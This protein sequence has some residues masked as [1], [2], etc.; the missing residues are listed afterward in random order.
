MISGYY[1][2]VDR[3]AITNNIQLSQVNSTDINKLSN[4]QIKVTLMIDQ[5]LQYMTRAIPEP[6]A[7][8]SETFGQKN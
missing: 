8:A 4:G 2:C 7:V 6:L 1:H 5:S 3:S